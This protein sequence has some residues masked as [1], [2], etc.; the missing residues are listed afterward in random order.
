M[1]RGYFLFLVFWFLPDLENW[2]TDGYSHC[3][4]LRARATNSQLFH[5]FELCT[6]ISKATDTIVVVYV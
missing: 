1:L 4:D 2:S 3:H 5:G 6:Q